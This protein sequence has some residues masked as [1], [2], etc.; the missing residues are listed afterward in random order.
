MLLIMMLTVLNLYKL[1]IKVIAS[2]QH[3]IELCFS[4]AKIY[5]GPLTIES[6]N[7]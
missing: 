5:L 7:E 4:V 1:F 2:N 3:S 6:Y